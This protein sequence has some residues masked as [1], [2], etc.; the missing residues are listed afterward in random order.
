MK[1]FQYLSVHV[2]GR[3]Q[4]EYKKSIKLKFELKGIHKCVLTHTCIFNSIALNRKL[5]HHFLN[6]N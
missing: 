4:T 5:P 6:D 3:L 2:Y 1:L